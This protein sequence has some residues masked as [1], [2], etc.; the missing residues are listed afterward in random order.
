MLQICETRQEE[1]GGMCGSGKTWAVF[2]D[3][4]LWDGVVVEEK[5]TSQEG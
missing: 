1:W 5:V 4:G 2:M 3:G